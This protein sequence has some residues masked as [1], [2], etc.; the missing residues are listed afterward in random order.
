MLVNELVNHLINRTYNVHSILD[1]IGRL[2]GTDSRPSNTKPAKPFKY[3]PLKALWGKHH[4][5]AKFI[6][7]NIANY[8]SSKNNKGQLST[9]IST[10]KEN[11][12]NKFVHEYVLGG[13]K[14]R[15]EEHK[16]TGEWIVFA[17]F[18]GRNFYLT[19]A[20]HNEG[21]DNVYERVRKS[22][23]ELPELVLPM[24]S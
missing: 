13:Y 4:F 23:V 17:K 1:E 20:S 14:A 3:P 18:D 9:L 22:A 10:L 8:W 11:T 5:Q 2:E 24:A 19:L 16:I 6:P 12:I 21:E 7:E 15:N